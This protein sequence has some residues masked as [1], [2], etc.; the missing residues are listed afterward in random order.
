MEF[1]ANIAAWSLLAFGLLMFLTQV[2][3]CEVGYSLGDNYRKKHGTS[4]AEGVGIVVGGLL[5]L[6]AFVL[7][8]TLSFG[9]SR[10]DERRTG[11]LAEAN[12]IGTAWLRAQAIGTPRSHE[13]AQQLKHYGQL[14]KEYIQASRDRS[15]LE[16]INKRTSAMQTE[17]WANASAIVRE[18]TDPVVV[19]LL[20]S[21]NEAF[22]TSTAA[23][24]AHEIRFPTSIFWLLISMT[25]ISAAALGYQLGLKAQRSHF[26]VALLIAVWTTV[27]VTILD[28]SAPRIGA[29]RTNIEVYD[30]TLQGFEE[31]APISP[32][33]ARK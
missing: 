13:I 18:R 1:L 25:H 4:E 9:S 3:A 17:I 29:I 31:G 19:S 10:Y 5:G 33:A 7:A 22:D 32:P 11:T 15:V 27:I 28:V 24:F 14:R 23:R 20:I 26:L 2:L 12:A 30:W 6:F 21:L 16:E 8:L